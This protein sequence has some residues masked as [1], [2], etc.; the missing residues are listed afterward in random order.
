MR[1][2]C[3]ILCLFL[4]LA[5]NGQKVTYYKDIAPI[6]QE[7]C[8]PCHYDNGYGPF[9]LASYEDVAKR[10]QF[11]GYVT[12]QRIMPPWKADPHYRSFAGEKQLSQ[13][14]IDLIQ[15]WIKAGAP[16]GRKKHAPPHVSFSSGSQLKAKP[17]LVLSMEHAVPLP[18]NNEH[19]FIC[20]AIPYELEQDTFVKAIEFVPENRQL[21][22]HNSYQILAVHPSV[23]L[24]QIPEYFVFSEDSINAIDDDHDYAFFNLNG[25]Q[26][27]KPVEVFHN[28]WL[29]G[30]SPQVY[31]KETGFF[32]PKKGVLLM[33]NLHYSPTPID[34]SDQ[35]RFHLHFA[36]GPIKRRVQFAAFKP[37]G[38]DYSKEHVI[39]ANTRDTFEMNI[40]LGG[41]VSLLHINPHMHYLGE[42]FEVYAI[43]PKGDTIP[44]VYIPDWDFNWQEFYRFKQM[45]HLPSGTIVYA[46]ATFDN[47]T[48]N[49]D[50]PFFP[51]RDIYFERGSMTET[52]EMMRLVFLYLP[53]R[54]GDE[55][56]SLEGL[57]E[58]VR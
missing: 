42:S 54:P 38:V 17:D 58:Q 55:M 41:A 50:N 43:P 32:L 45:L 51:P 6:F 48:E 40:R 49:P 44:L 31:P 24:S 30:V 57:E 13:T 46:R 35:S 18:G 47:T 52:E 36:D 34:T 15:Q 23:D 8:L 16:K 37:T 27:E 12:D 9:S 3:L 25:S 56:I 21:V 11:V 7:N 33:R 39:T 2:N 20:Y 5:C 22:H 29:P 19:L 28:G 1:F 14:E 26:G 53:Y 4:G 10:A